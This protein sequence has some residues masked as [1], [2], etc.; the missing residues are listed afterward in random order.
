MLYVFYGSNIKKGVEKAHSLINSL[1]TKKPDAAFEILN[2]ENWN[3]SVL[4]GHLGGQGLFSNKYI[5]F[6]DRLTENIEA[7]EQLVDF[8]PSLQES[9][10]IFILLEGKV[11]AELKKALIKHAEKVVEC[12][13][14]KAIGTRKEE[15][16]IFSI[17]DAFGARDSF[18]AWSIYRRAIES[19]VG[20]ENIIGILFWK[21]KSMKSSLLLKDL[22]VLYHD[23]HRGRLDLELGIERAL[24]LC[25]QQDSNLRPSA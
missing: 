15:F 22:I 25:A 18:K 13:E 8:V 11:L 21:A 1:R 10:N 20:P 4:E 7:K 2:A 12:E 23:G 9:S 16:N 19:G 17:A 3:P 14:E 24:L 6:L 5:I